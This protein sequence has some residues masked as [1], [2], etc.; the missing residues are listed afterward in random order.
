MQSQAARML[1]AKAERMQRMSSC[2]HGVTQCEHR[3]APETMG[4]RMMALP[5]P[6]KPND[7]SLTPSYSVG[8][9]AR[10]AG[11]ILS[12]R[13][14]GL[15]M[16]GRLGPYTS[17]SKMPT[18]APICA[19]VYARFTATVDLPTPA[20]HGISLSWSMFLVLKLSI[21][22]KP[23]PDGGSSKKTRLSFSGINSPRPCQCL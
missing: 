10:V 17:A 8:S 15:T 6:A 9:S 5:C 12:T 23:E 3:S 18:R 13:S 19:S 14:A 22:L 21:N 11:S 7:T 16:V 2:A 20:R 4:P 1:A